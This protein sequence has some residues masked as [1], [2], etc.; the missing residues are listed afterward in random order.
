MK[1]LLLFKKSYTGYVNTY[2]KRNDLCCKNGYKNMKSENDSCS[3]TIVW[4]HLS[5]LLSLSLVFLILVVKY[6]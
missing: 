6:E 4:E 1:K 5:L 3:K 2:G